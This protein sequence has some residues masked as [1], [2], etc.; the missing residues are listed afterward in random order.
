M[1]SNIFRFILLFPIFYWIYLIF[2]SN[3]GADPAKSLNHKAG[4]I[5]LYYIL[6]NLG[7]G[8][9]I[10][11]KYRFPKALRFLLSN[12]RYLGVLSFIILVFHLF[13]YFAMESFEFKAIEQMYTKTYLICA[14]LAFII[15]SVLAFTSNDFFVKRLT[16]KKW[17]TLHRA[18]Y[19]AMFLFSIHVLLI[20]K[21]DLIKYGIIFFILWLFQ[22]VRLAQVLY[23]RKDKPRES[24]S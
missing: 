7:V 21:T 8:I 6:L 17:K 18:I 13:L 22:A 3:M 16:I 19:V 4:E 12:R 15:L 23:R 2:F 24:A 10:S 14:S 1:I 5:A 20:E 11:F 9:L